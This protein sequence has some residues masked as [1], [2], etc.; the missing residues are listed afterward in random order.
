MWI[1]GIECNF[2]HGLLRIGL[3]D[4][5]ICTQLTKSVQSRETS[6]CVDGNCRYRYI[7]SRQRP[8]PGMAMLR[9]WAWCLAL[10]GFSFV[11]T[12][13]KRQ[14][15]FIYHISFFY[16]SCLDHPAVFQIADLIS[17]TDGSKVDVPH[18]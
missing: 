15:L 9:R 1:S 5:Q 10:P 12:V 6:H 11:F 14:A 4:G 7:N 16:N 18:A 8:G 13:A 3:Q 17:S 2:G